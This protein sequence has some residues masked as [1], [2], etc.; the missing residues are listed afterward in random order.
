M[1][2][3]VYSQYIFPSGWW[4]HE[5]EVQMEPPLWL[6][7]SWCQDAKGLSRLTACYDLLMCPAHPPLQWSRELRKEAQGMQQEHFS[8]EQIRKI[9]SI[10]LKSL[11]DSPDLNTHHK[12][13]EYFSLPLVS[14]TLLPALPCLLNK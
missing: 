4:Q 6:L 2:D 7:G 14:V 3:T 1:T 8:H 11:P 12:D 13:K 5:L 9:K 10:S